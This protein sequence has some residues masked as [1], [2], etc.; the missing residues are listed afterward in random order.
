M[1]RSKLRVGFIG[2]GMI[3]LKGHIP[4]WKLLKDEAQI[5]AVADLQEERAR[6][7]AREEGIPHAYGDWRSMLR[8]QELDVVHVCTP[9]AYHK[10]QTIA[11]LRAGAH[12]CCEKPA[13]PCRADAEAMFEAA[14]A[15]RRHL[16]I[17]QSAR[18][19]SWGR[20]AK[21]I[22][23][24]GRLGEIYFADG[25][26]L[27]RR[28]VP[29]WGWF[30]MKRHSGGGV[31]H[32]VGVHLVDLVYWILGNPRV[33]SVSAVTYSKIAPRGEKVETSVA[34]SG[35]FEGVRFARP[36]RS[37]DFDVEDFAAAFIRLSDGVTFTL[38]LSWAA[39]I[40][41]N[42]ESTCLLGTKGGLFWNPLTLV[43]NV[44][45]Y[46]ATTSLKLPPDE[47]GW[48]TAHRRQAAHFLRVL[49]GEEELLVRREPLDL[50]VCC[51]ENARHAEVVEACAR[52]GVGVCVEKP[53]A[54]NLRQA[55]AMVRAARSA[56]TLLLVN[57]PMTWNPAARAAKELLDRGAVGRVL[58][59][60]TRI[61]HT[62][63]L[64]AGARH[65]GVSE[66]A[67]PLS[68]E[69]LGAVW[70]HREAEGGGATLDFCGYGAM[71]ARWFLGRPAQAALGMRANLNSPWGDAD[72]NGVL[73]VRFPSALARFEA[74]WTTADHGVGGGPVVYGA[75]GT[76]VL[77]E[78]EGRVSLTL[79]RGG[80]REACP[81]PPL[82]PGRHDLAHE[83]V[84]H[85]ETGEPL[86]P[87]LDLPVNLDAMAILD[88]GL[89][90][91]DS[92]KLEPVDDAVWCVGS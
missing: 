40:P 59:I 11:A 28:G 53:M 60:T 86:H 80:R 73:V 21:E 82:P 46:Q 23:D 52:A 20:A 12:V 92:G 55:L 61:G 56:G 25:Q 38:R 44:G 49:R 18:F 39:N 76:L 22:A 9:N 33:R 17:G 91:A 63:P 35:A 71:I 43:S 47:H 13:A 24:S 69:E 67:A 66:E 5:V 6:R 48:F 34:D 4:G 54:A 89:R 42:T 27:R 37:R 15:A 85:L 90:S 62:G 79:C 7:V 30:H 84:H 3:A 51:S 45:R 14:R 1:G 68:P 16:F 29:T 26:A 64:G 32:D 88:A 2:A 19:I 58:M 65:A 10:E 50:V 77:E 78:G 70:W 72:D 57:W 75:E 31:V 81:L 41:D 8:E 74:S 36:Y 83:V 87:T